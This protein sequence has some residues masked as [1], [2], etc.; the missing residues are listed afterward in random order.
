MPPARTKRRTNDSDS[1]SEGS[2]RYSGVTSTDDVSSTS[3][4]NSSSVSL[5]ATSLPRRPIRSKNP[6]NSIHTAPNV[7]SGSARLPAAIVASA[8]F[9]ETTQSS[10]DLEEGDPTY[11]P[12]R[13]HSTDVSYRSRSPVPMHN[14]NPKGKL[15]EETKRAIKAYEI[16]YNVPHKQ[17]PITLERR[18]RKSPAFQWAHMIPC[19]TKVDE[20]CDTTRFYDLSAQ[21]DC[22]LHVQL[23]F[24]EWCLGTGAGSFNINSSQNVMPR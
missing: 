1:G 14:V 22:W 8:A 16:K 24:I 2:T 4:S 3:V 20:V 5:S 18:I 11:R 21:T 17:C 9:S 10:E 15:P 6:R 7:S 13:H 12:E 23:R 19:A